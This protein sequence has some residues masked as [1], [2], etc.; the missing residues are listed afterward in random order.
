ME[1]N[2][3]AAP[4]QSN[5]TNWAKIGLFGVVGVVAVVAT[6]AV[7]SHAGP[8]SLALKQLRAEEDIFQSW[9]QEHN[10][11]YE[12]E[13]EYENR[14]QTFRDNAAA[15][16]VHNQQG[17]EFELGHNQ[18]SD[19]STSEFTKLVSRPFKVSENRSEVY[20][21]TDSVPASV[22]WRL[23]GAVTAVKNQGQCGSCW[24][25][26]TTGSV[27]GINAIKT[28]KLTSLSEQQ[29]VDCSTSYGNQG[30]N[31]GLMDDAFQYI[32]ATGGLETESQ[33]PYTGADG[34]CKVSQSSLVDPITS[35]ADV[36]A[37]NN[38]QLQAAVA[39]QPVSI[40]IQANQF[41]FQF[42]KTGVLKSGCGTNLD[43]G[44]LIVGYDTDASGTPYWIVKNSW[45]ATW[46]QS[47][48]IWIARSSSTSD[49]GVCGIAMS[50]SYPTK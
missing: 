19:M 28:G 12:T 3:R 46:G 36:P 49:A 10:R 22:D 27:E 29:L 35:F 2:F 7:F 15:I 5:K 31:G 44:V 14:F 4:G 47:G 43:H 1:T 50:A 6:V 37:K 32:I 40:A 30:C 39:I 18:F 21:S 45:G 33:Y 17:F 9:I 26:S 41:A 48:Y 20:L 34:T 25:F 11:A 8:S 42:Y 13:E 16:R 38:V 23:K 24:S